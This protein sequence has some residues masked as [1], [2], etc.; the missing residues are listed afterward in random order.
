MFEKAMETQKTPYERAVD[1]AK[2]EAALARQIGI[3]AWGLSKL[4]KQKL[5]IKRCLAIEKFTD[6]AV[7]GE[8]LRPDVNWEY[9]RGHL[10]EFA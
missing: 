6:G 7:T 4:N 10:E 1:I 5:P 8:E 9:V 2:T 3:T